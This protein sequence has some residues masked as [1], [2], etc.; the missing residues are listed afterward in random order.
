MTAEFEEKVFKTIK[1]FDLISSGDKIIVAISGG[2]DSVALLNFLVK[3]KQIL[4][5]DILA[6]HIN[7]LIRKESYKDE[8]LVRNLCKNLKVRLKIFRKDIPNLAKKKKMSLEEAGRFFRYNVFKKLIRKENFTKI[9]TAHHL[10]DIIETFLLRLFKGTSINGLTSIP[11]KNGNIIRPLIEVTKEEIFSYLEKEKIKFIIDKT[12]LV[13]TYERN[14]IRNIIFPSMISRF[15][16]SKSKIMDL[17]E[18]F[19]LIQE[20]FKCYI[21]ELTSKG[22]IEKTQSLVRIDLSKIDFIKNR[23]FFSELIRRLVKENF[24]LDLNREILKNI[25]S[26][27]SSNNNCG[28]KKVFSAKY[29]EMI[30]EYNYL[31]ISSKFKDQKKIRTKPELYLFQNIKAISYVKGIRFREAKI[32]SVDRDFLLQKAKEKVFYLSV[33]EV[34]E[35][36]AR[37]R[38]PGDFMYIKE[39]RKKIKDILIDYKIPYSERKNAVVV[40]TDKGD[41]CLLKS[42]NLIRVSEKYFISNQTR[43]MIEIRF[44]D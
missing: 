14:Y 31:T 41:I 7:H 18:D 33:D 42:G 17:I 19:R 38:K 43:N 35:L 26:Q 10:D 29:L 24:Y 4:K 27:V 39:G 30:R 37:F 34:K 32:S 13:N 12:N 21:E 28:N 5:I 20:F 25:F 15:P 40:E 11:P 2:P 36:K 22:I 8:N 9:A 23:F 3:N 6:T 1:K 16:N 44:T